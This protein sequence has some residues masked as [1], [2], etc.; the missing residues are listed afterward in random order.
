MDLLT[1]LILN[2]LKNRKSG[3]GEP[4]TQIQYIESTGDPQYINFNFLATRGIKIVVDYAFLDTWKQ[5][6]AGDSTEQDNCFGL[7]QFTSTERFYV[8][9]PVSRFIFYF[10]T[11]CK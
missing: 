9:Y 4:H 10:W 3:G 2:K 7:G 6:G 1:T 5:A 8:S 11:W